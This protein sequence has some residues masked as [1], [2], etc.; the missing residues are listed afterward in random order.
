MRRPRAFGACAASL[1][2][3]TGLLGLALIC[4]VARARNNRALIIDT[5]AGSD[6]LMAIAFLLSRDDIHIEAITVANGLAHVRAGATNLLRLLELSGNKNIPVYIGCE[7][8]LRGSAAF[9]EEWRTVSDTLP[10]VQL[11]ATSRAPEPQSAAE[12]LATRLREPGAQVRILA[13]G[14]LTNLAEALQRAPSSVRAIAEVVMMGGAVRVPGNLG[15]G[16]YFHTDNKTA[17]WNMFV[18]PLAAKIV[19]NSGAKIRLIPLDATNKVPIDTS[20]LREFES[21]ARTPLGRFVAQILEGD[22]KFIEQGIYSA[23]DPLAAVALVHPAVVA[24]RPLAIEIRQQSPEEGRTTEISG[25]RPNAKVALDAN[26]ALFKEI[27]FR[28]F[29][30]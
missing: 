8:P 20:F 11:P 4:G 9:P 10:G 13:L 12:Y 25:G 29:V 18:D 7:Q 26:A 1:L 24:T 21:R 27:F 30:D 16:G 6:D 22:R 2:A 23:W 3:F 19:F 28:A 17:E 5:D 14:P 15:D